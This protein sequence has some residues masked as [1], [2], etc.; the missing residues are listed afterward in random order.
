MSDP[1]HVCDVAGLLDKSVYIK[2]KR[3]VIVFSFNICSLLL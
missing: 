2:I 1:Q 3:V